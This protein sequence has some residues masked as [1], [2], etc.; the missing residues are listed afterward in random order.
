[1]QE[2][3]ERSGPAEPITPDHRPLRKFG[4]LSVMLFGAF[5]LAVTLAWIVFLFWLTGWLIEVLF[6]PDWAALLGVRGAALCPTCVSWL[7]QQHG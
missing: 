6:E 1:M 4:E 2:H 7:F 3:E 5:A